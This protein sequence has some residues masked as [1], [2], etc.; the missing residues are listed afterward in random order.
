MVS[1]SDGTSS[2]KESVTISCRLDGTLHKLLLKDAEESGVSLNSLFN[3]IMRR[4]ISWE[5]YA[6]VV[7]F[8]PLATDTVRLIFDDMSEKTM[9]KIAKQ[10]GRTIPRQLILLMFNKIDFNSVLSFLEITFSRYGM[11]QH[12]I[13]GSA[14]DFILYHNVNKRFSQFLAEVGKIM[15]EDLSIKL[16]VT[17]VD[18]RILSIRIEENREV[19]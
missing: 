13:R 3:S 11:V 8:V 16:D 2:K 7:G 18:S 1:V 15:A 17:S 19:R 10:V 12:T 14:H 4:Y 5:K 9:R 6:N